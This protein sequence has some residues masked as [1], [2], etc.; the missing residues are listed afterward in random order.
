MLDPYH[1]AVAIILDNDARELAIDLAV[2]GPCLLLP[3]NRVPRLR[4]L[5]RL[6]GR[7]RLAFGRGRIVGRCCGRAPSLGRDGGRRCGDGA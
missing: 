1:V 2:V 3:F 5:P 6:R 4:L 7:R